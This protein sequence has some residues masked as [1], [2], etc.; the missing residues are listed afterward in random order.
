MTRKEKKEKV[1]EIIDLV[2]SDLQMNE[3]QASP[4][5]LSD[6]DYMRDEV[7]D[8]S[9]VKCIA[10]RNKGDKYELENGSIIELNLGNMISNHTEVGG[11]WFKSSECAYI[12]SIYSSNSIDCVR[13]QRTLSAHTNGLKAKRV[14]RNLTNEHSVFQR[15]DF[16]FF[17]I[18]FMKFVILS[19]IRSNEDFRNLLLSIPDNVMLI[20]DVS[21]LKGSKKLVWGAENIELKRIKKEKLKLL[22]QRL[23]EDNIQFSKR[24]TQM[25]NNKIHSIGCYCGKNIMGKILTEAVIRMK[26]Y[27]DE[28][29]IIV[30]YNLLD[31]K[32]IYWFGE[33]LNF[34]K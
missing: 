5:R 4:I 3:V 24:Y 7:Y 21:F 33:K 14:Y 31:S 20:E 34:L 15:V 32:N 13:I 30:D 27:T 28:P 18:E 2:I 9:K 19:K 1:N 23:L 16:D 8:T 12:S 22:K 11:I 26:H 25:L 29:E 10:F 6:I 17:N